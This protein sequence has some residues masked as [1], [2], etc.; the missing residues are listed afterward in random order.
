VSGLTEVTKRALRAGLALLALLAAGPAL[1]QTPTPEPPPGE[2]DPGPLVDALLS[3]LLGFQEVGEAELQKEVEEAGGVPFRQEVKVD[4]M[5]RA[6]LGRFLR[7]LFD[8]EYPADRA[9]I[10]ERVLVALDLLPETTDLRALRA[11]VLE[12]NIAG[13]YDERPGKKR[14]YAVSESRRFGP[15]NQL[16]LSH[17]LRHALQDQ[18]VDL[19]AQIPESVSDYDDRRLAWTALLEGDATLVMERFLM[20]R[21]PGGGE[22]LPAMPLPETPDLPG[23]P[24]V[25]RDQLV[26]PYLV[27]RDFAQALWAR[28][29]GKALQAAWSRPPRSTEQ[30]LHPEKYFANEEPRTVSVPV[31]TAG[32]PVKDGVLGE[33]LIRTFLEGEA[34]SAGRGWGGDQYRLFDVG[35]KTLLVWRSVWDRPED[36]QRFLLEARARFARKHGG[37]RRRGAFSEYGQGRW[38]YAIGE[39]GGTAVYVSSDDPRSFDTT[40]S[41][42]TG[43]PSREAVEPGGPAL[44]VAAFVDNPERPLDN[45][46]AE[47][48]TAAPPDPV[49]PAAPVPQG[50]SMASSAPGQSNL[51]MAPNVGGLLCYVPC[52]IG[53]IFSVVVAIVE[54]QSR[55]MRFHAFQSLLLH[56]AAL[57][58]SIALQLVQIILGIIHLGAV[59]LLLGL[60]GM[61]IGVGFLGLSIFMMIKANGGEEFAL[62]VIGDMARKWA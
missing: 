33:L 7:E 39:E 61:V 19:Q 62:P 59:G 28:G 50:G 43:V 35:G 52:C 60:V 17:E 13:F 16:I 58:V 5:G 8:A 4:F 32:T 34:G 18:Y 56:A 24:P 49:R 26:L 44:P 54:K 31:A 38:R 20:R 47:P 15:A 57:A 55:F 46:P 14:L 41:G 48:P 1:A 10:D 9:R 53:L 27:G 23:A 11:R 22:E 29:G 36:Q 42:L 21:L 25:V 51:G 6:E 2:A 3:G 40:L 45:A 12:E 37:E 30:V